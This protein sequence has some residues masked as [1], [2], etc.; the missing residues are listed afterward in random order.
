MADEHVGYIRVSSVYQ[1]TE[2]QLEGLSLDRL[3][4]DKISAKDTKRPALEECLAY[5]RTGDTLHIHSIDRLA[6]NL[7]DLQDIVGGLTSKGI[8]I[9]FE[10]ESLEFQ[11]NGKTNPMTKLMLH[12]MG[13]FAEFERELILERQREGIELAKRAGKY[14]GR[15]R[16]LSDEQGQELRKRVEAG[17]SKAS[18]AREFGISRQVVYDYLKRGLKYKRPRKTWQCPPEPNHRRTMEVRNG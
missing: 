4:E 14:K 12:M 8:H 13:A 6:R 15:K 5:L 10:K 16:S 17:A 3:F 2:R 7:R 1:N 11:A 9:R 18:I